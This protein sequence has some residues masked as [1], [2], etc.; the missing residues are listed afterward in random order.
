MSAYEIS[1]IALE[2]R[3]WDLETRKITFVGYYLLEEEEQDSTFDVSILQPPEMVEEFLGKLRFSAVQNLKEK[4]QDEKVQVEFDNETFLRQKIYN[5]FKRISMELTNPRRKKGQPK[6]ILTTHMDVYNENQDVSFLPQ[7]FQFYIILNWARKY[8]LRDDTEGYKK[9]IEPL[10]KLIRVAPDYGLGY[11]MLARSLKKVRKYD[12]AMRMYERYAEVDDSLDAWL[13]LAKSYRKGKLFDKSEEIY[14]NVLSNHPDDKVAL[15]GLAQIYYATNQDKYIGILDNLHQKDSEWLREWLVD[16]F[17]FRIYVPEK[18]LFSPIQ[19]AKFLGFQ[20]IFELTQKAFKNEIP[21]HFNP[22]KARMS[23]YKEELENWAMVMN[24]FNCLKEPVNVYPDRID[25]V[26]DD[27][28]VIEEEV[29]SKESSVKKEGS[30]DRQLTQVEEILLQ[31]RARK[32]QRAAAAIQSGPLE[33]DESGKNKS[34]GHSNKNGKASPQ[35]SGNKKLEEIP[36]NEHSQDETSPKT[37]G[38]RASKK[39]S[40][41]KS[42]DEKDSNTGEG[43]ASRQTRRKSTSKGKNESEGSE[44]V[45]TASSKKKTTRKKAENKKK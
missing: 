15:I 41:L 24:R 26:G 31:I 38:K 19:A 12:E 2:V 33:D 28:T 29:I 18:T 7:R 27:V 13:D 35:K 36:A 43:K 22:T 23:F 5:Y 34:K 44:E 1:L 45:E 25:Q 30:N 21:S 10:R 17:N 4:H 8:Y 6:L 11:K 39:S 3:K 40:N 14:Q 32:A 37:R 20:K 9:A 16:E 42:S